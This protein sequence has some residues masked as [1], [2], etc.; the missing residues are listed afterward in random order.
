MLSEDQIPEPQPKTDVAVGPDIATPPPA[1]PTEGQPQ[2][3]VEKPKAKTK[4]PLRIGVI[5]NLTNL[6]DIAFYNAQFRQINQ[7][8]PT[9]INLLF[10]GYRPE[11]DTDNALDGVNFDYVKPVSI[12]HY[13]KQ[14]KALNIDLLFIP[15][16]QNVYN[17]T[18]ENYNKWLEAG[19]CSTPIIAPDIYPYNKIVRDK[20]NGFIFSNREGFV[21]YLKDLLVNHFG[22]IKHCGNSAME[23]VTKK[24]NFSMENIRVISGIFNPELTEEE[25][26]EQEEHQ[27]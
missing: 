8:Q 9:N 17:A 23:E 18:S 2:P 12:I 27:E 14:F 11:A 6:E 20:Q 5:V 10:F 13:F 19:L 21:P 24:F 15:L 3:A 16:I 22:L 7:W 4:R 1:A 25:Q 26:Q